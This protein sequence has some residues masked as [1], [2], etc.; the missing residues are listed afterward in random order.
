[1]TPTID[2]IEITTTYLN[3]CYNNQIY[4]NATSECKKSKVNLGVRQ[5]V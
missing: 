1:M 5:L 2:S 3:N 4:Y